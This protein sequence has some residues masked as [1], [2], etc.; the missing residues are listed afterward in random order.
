MKYTSITPTS[1]APIESHSARVMLVNIQAMTAQPSQGR[2]P[3][4]G[5]RNGVPP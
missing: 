2:I 1:A 5:A 3:G 4:A